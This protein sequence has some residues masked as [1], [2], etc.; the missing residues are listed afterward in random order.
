MIYALAAD[1]FA[2]LQRLSLLYH[3]NRSPGDS[4]SRLTED[5]WCVD[6]V[7]RSLLL[8]PAQNL[9]TLCA[10]SAVAFSLDP[11]L[12]VLSLAVAPVLGVGTFF[13]GR[14][15]KQTKRE[16]REARTS[17]ISFVHQTLGAIPVVQA[18]GSEWR[19]LTQ[20]RQASATAV[21]A[22]QRDRLVNAG[23]ALFHGITVTA[24]VAVII[25]AGGQ[26]VLTGAMTVGT[27]LVFIA[28]IRS[29]QGAIQGLLATYAQL[30]SA[31]ASIDRVLEVLDIQ[32]HVIE[33]ADAEPLPRSTHGA[34]VSF[35]S[36]TFG[37]EPSRPILENISLE[38][39]PGETVALVG[40][41][42]AGKST[43][44]NMIPRFFDPW[45]GRIT[46]NGLDIRDVQIRSLRAQISVV[47]QEPFLLP[48]T[49]AQ[50]V[51]YSR[52]EASLEEVQAAAAAANADEFIRQLPKGYETMLH[53]RGA[54]LSGGQKQRI[55]IAR[56]LLKD[57]PILILDEPTSALDAE[58]EALISKAL[59]RLMSGRTV[60]VIAHR[61]SLVR[62]ADRIVVLEK[63]R[64]TEAGTHGELLR[65]R[66]LY[67][68][69]HGLQEEA[70]KT[71]ST[72]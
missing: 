72:S 16:E 63:G 52:P 22:V 54:N 38:A 32:D 3:V 57:A 26:R 35:E 8:A 62:R 53:E 14:R 42:G 29:M 13:F 56:A 61:F 15:M 41:T 31:E 18:F 17:L 69:L 10:V 20:F 68:E 71:D 21:A 33:K 70:I 43:L 27:L 30:K 6:S 28:Y 37:Y 40:R 39:L 5:T 59:E 25:Y 24:G 50:N 67:S 60:F 44:A 58:S 48:L 46:I 2:R 51:A 47:P 64:I 49:I 36:V 34:H 11:G 23:Y 9:L 66:G 19:N 7:V 55:A 12:T 45:S 1:L 65:S 4:L